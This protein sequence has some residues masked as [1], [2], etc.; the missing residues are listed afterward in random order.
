MKS[1]IQ[2]ILCLFMLQFF[3]LEVYGQ[4]F[5]LPW[6]SG[7]SHYVSRTGSPAPTGSTGSSCGPNSV[8]NYTAHGYVAIDFDT[9]NN[10]YDPVRAVKAGVVIFAGWNGGYGNL[11]RVRHSDG[12]QTY[13]AHND[14]IFVSTGQSVQQGCILADGGDTGNSFGDHIHFEWRD[15]GGVPFSDNRYPSFLE[16]SCKVKAKYCYT[17]T[18]SNGACTGTPCT[19]PTNDNCSNATTIISNGP[20]LSG[21][22]KCATGSF[23]A[24]QCDGC[25]CSSPDDL[26][27]Y[28]KFVAQATSHTV[29]LSNYASNFDGVI[30]LRSGCS[31]GTNLGCYDPSGVPNSISRTFNGLTVGQTYYVRI[32]EW[33]NINTPPSSPT[34]KVKVTHICPLPGNIQ[35]ISGNTS[36]CSNTTQ[37]Y[38]VAAVSNATSYTWTLP[39]GWTGTSTSNS[40]TVNVGNNGGQISVKANN[41]CGSSDLVTKQID[42]SIMPSIPSA[43]AGKSTLCEGPSQENYSISPVSGATSFTWTLPLGWTGSSNSTLI[44][45]TTDGTGGTIKVK[46][47]SGCGSGPERTLEVTAIN[48][49]NT[50]NYINGELTAN[51]AGAS[52]QWIDCSTNYPINGATNQSFIPN[53]IGDYA[54]VLTMGNC[55]DTSAC[56][57][58]SDLG[59]TYSDQTI[60]LI[61]Y[62]N[63]TR[64]TVSIAGKGLNNEKH[65]IRF[66]NVQGQVFI[67]EEFSINNNKLDAQFDIRKLPSG[68]YFISISS[69]TLKHVFKLEKI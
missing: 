23:G 13:Y 69:G 25:N 33:D 67:H 18:N 11:V 64:N 24:N 29:T 30:E 49:D 6:N 32:F 26:D 4:G 35:N 50:V 62:P 66:T 22:V 31:L 36:I 54:V 1:K 51:A 7:V 19:A 3:A 46:A 21:T 61:A 15:V 65:H 60:Q 52:Y 20:T 9:P 57:S 28:F 45:A 48:L 16:C 43:I 12:T 58:V 39:S 14:A 47:N 40:I 27:V 2:L 44:S 56:V 5:K 63:P 17:S 34:F 41:N 55:I 68:L 10:V 38:S 8:Y 42:V 53:Q 37:T 59:L